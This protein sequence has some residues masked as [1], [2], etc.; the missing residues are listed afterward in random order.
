MSLLS[1]SV[2]STVHM[3]VGT[4]W[5]LFS[6][7]RV[8][9]AD[10]HNDSQQEKNTCSFPRE[11]NG[12]HMHATIRQTGELDKLQTESWVLEQS[13]FKVIDWNVSDK[14][15]LLVIKLIVEMLIDVWRSG[16]SVFAPLVQEPQTLSTSTE[17]FTLLALHSLQLYITAEI[18]TQRQALVLR[19]GSGPECKNTDTHCEFRFFIAL[20]SVGTSQ[21]CSSMQAYFMYVTASCPPPTAKNRR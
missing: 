14:A 10:C 5:S 13:L 8:G 18:Q 11:L 21:E 15:D 20:A 9:H 2:S 19:G 16:W 17:D 12:D 3:F 6:C 4:S 7:V 1:A